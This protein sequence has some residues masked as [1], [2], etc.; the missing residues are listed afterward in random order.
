MAENNRSAKDKQMA[1]RLKREGVERNTGRCAI[2]YRPIGN[3][4]AAE[5]HYAAHARGVA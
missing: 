4:K 1:A 2:C 5:Q 3:G